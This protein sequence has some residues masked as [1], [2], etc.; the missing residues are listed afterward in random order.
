MG[1]KGKPKVKN[2]VGSGTWGLRLNTVIGTAAASF[3]AVV[4]QDS[5]LKT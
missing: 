3:V 5:G 1:E 4:I 2:T